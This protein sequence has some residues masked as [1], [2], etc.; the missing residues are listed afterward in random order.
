MLAD[1]FVKK[2]VQPFCIPPTVLEALWGD[3]D[4]WKFFPL[5][6]ELGR[7]MLGYQ[8]EI[9]SALSRAMKEKQQRKFLI[10]VISIGQILEV[11]VGER[12]GDFS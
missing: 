6:D 12:L 11:F 4:K 1:E 5:L 7:T 8:I 3:D 9:V 2:R 10:A